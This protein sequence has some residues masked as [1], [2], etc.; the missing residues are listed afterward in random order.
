MAS[1]IRDE[2]L[3]KVADSVKPDSKRRVSIPEGLLREGLTYHIY[4]NSL[5]QIVFNPSVL[6][7]RLKCG[8]L[9]TKRR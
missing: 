8:Y 1:I 9:K 6:Y 5:G 3:T 4:I 2:K 7:L